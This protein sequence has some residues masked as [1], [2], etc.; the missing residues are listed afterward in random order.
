[1]GPA[2]SRPRAPPTPRHGG[3]NTPR[4]RHHDH[5]R[6]GPAPLAFAR[7]WP[8]P[9]AAPAWSPTRPARLLTHPPTSPAVL[10][11]RAAPGRGAPGRRATLGSCDP[12]VVRPPSGAGRPGTSAVSP[13]G[14]RYLRFDS[15]EGYPPSTIR[16]ARLQSVARGPPAAYQPGHLPGVL[17]LSSGDAGLGEG[18]PLRCFQRFARPNVATQRCRRSDNWHTSGSSTPVLSY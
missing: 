5:D 3:G 14:V 12:A 8:A 10:L 16:T 11:T 7:L 17:P 15:H 13:S 1:M 6:S 4:L 2:R 9:A 18:F